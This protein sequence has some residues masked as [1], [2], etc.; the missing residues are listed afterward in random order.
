MQQFSKVLLGYCSFVHICSK[1][2]VLGIIAITMTGMSSGQES[3]DIAFVLKSTG[4]VHIGKVREKKWIKS[5]RGVRVNSGNVV[6]TGSNSFASLVFTDDKSMIKV[7]S[8]S[9]VTINGKRNKKQV[10][11]SLFMRLGQMWSKVTKGSLFQIE[12]PSGV[13]AVKGTEWYTI[14][15]SDGTQIIFCLEGSIELS[16]QYGTLLINAGERGII[17]RDTGPSK[18]PVRDGEMPG[19]ATDMQDMNLEIEFENDAK[20]KKKLKIRIR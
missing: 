19:W 2:S 4:K 13:A 6:R 11:K 20:E 5:Y 7:R 10:K 16:N 1:I 18:R 15:T 3:Q 17:Q 8:K 14:V 9:R 12:S